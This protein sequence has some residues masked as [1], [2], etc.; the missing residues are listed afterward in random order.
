MTHTTQQPIRARDL[1]AAG[2]SLHSDWTDS[3]SVGAYQKAACG[4]TGGQ[5]CEHL[6]CT[7]R[8]RQDVRHV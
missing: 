1:R 4:R 5:E 7:E 3:S 6:M 2:E 8:V